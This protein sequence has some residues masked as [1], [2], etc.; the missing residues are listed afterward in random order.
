MSDHNETLSTAQRI[1]L[2]RVEKGWTQKQLADA[3]GIAQ[4]DISRYERGT[5]SPTATTVDRLMKAIGQ[6]HALAAVDGALGLQ[7]RTK[8]KLLPVD[9]MA[10]PAAIEWIVEGLVARGF[11]TMIAGAAGAGKS[12]VTQTIAEAAVSGR[13]HVLGMKLHHRTVNDKCADCGGVGGDQETASVCETCDGSGRI[14]RYDSRVLVIDAENAPNI[15]QDRAQH[16]GL[17]GDV[18]DRYI[19]QVSDGF[20]IYKDRDSLDA[21]LNDYR[22]AGT[23]IDLLV[24]DS[25]KSLWF[26]NENAVEQVQMCLGYLNKTAD[27][28]GIGILLIHHTDKDGESARGSSSIAAT[29]GGAVFTFTKYPEKENQDQTAR[30][31]AC[32]KMRIAREP[33]PARLYLT[34]H[35]VDTEPESTSERI[36][37]LV[38]QRDEE[39]VDEY[40]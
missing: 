22:E 13:D 8:G 7:G 38:A 37:A 40:L 16:M 35:G 20:D 33:A 19:A 23:P 9:M 12:M 31:L 26:G 21:I 27:R 4:G 14:E 39:P 34:G 29:I 18:V 28:F 2:A 24:L 11:L 36:A 5:L 6:T 3:S 30:R 10:E 32:E 17:T 25:W 1:K 15:V